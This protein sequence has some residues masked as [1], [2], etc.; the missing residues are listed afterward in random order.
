MKRALLAIGLGLAWVVLLLLA[1]RHPALRV[2]AAAILVAIA[3][4]AALDAAMVL[5][6]SVRSR[7]P[8]VALQ[9]AGPPIEEIAAALR[10]LLWDH[11]E[12]LRSPERV[13]PAG[14]LRWLEKRIGDRAVQ[15]AQA[16]EV[17]HPSRPVGGYSRP[18]LGRLLHELTCAG[19]VLPR[20][21]VLLAPDNRR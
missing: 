13:A 2:V 14:R 11:D 12:L 20:S 1:V 5:R 6:R 7:R 17:S 10:Q 18:Q 16:I 19:L 15:A 4:S 21:V 8:S 9:P 3:G